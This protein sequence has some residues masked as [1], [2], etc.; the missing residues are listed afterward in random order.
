[1]QEDWRLVACDPDM[2]DDETENWVK[3]KLSGGG[4][5]SLK[6]WV[7]PIDGGEAKTKEDQVAGVPSCR[8]VKSIQKRSC[9][10]DVFLF[11]FFNY[12]CT[13]KWRTGNIKTVDT[14]VKTVKDLEKGVIFFFNLLSCFSNFLFCCHWS[15]Y[16]ALEPLGLN[17]KRF[18]GL[19]PL[20]QYVV[21]LKSF[22]NDSKD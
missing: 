1:M 16:R 18:S 21:P 17:W 6:V 14:I 4:N 7:P 15:L 9:Q 10:W 22:M 20:Y 13:V 3:M 5:G 11:Y 12:F 8:V 2:R 19:Q